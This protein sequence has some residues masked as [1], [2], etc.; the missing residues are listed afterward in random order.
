MTRGVVWHAEAE[1]DVSD[2]ANYIALHRLSA[3]TR[4]LDAVDTTVL[5]LARMPGSGRLREFSKPLLTGLRSRPIEAFPNYL[6]FY[7]RLERAIEVVRVLHGAR[8]LD[9]IFRDKHDD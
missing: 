3:A 7:R 6:V 4:F 5:A 1:R 8:N 9:A 2:A